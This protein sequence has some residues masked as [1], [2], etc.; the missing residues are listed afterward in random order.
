M[1]MVFTISPLE[2]LTDI[3][4]DTLSNGHNDPI[5][6]LDDLPN[7]PFD[8]LEIIFDPLE[9][10]ADLWVLNCSDPTIEVKTDM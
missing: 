8:L 2:T 3:P 7:V 4:E 6:A 9:A 1:A 10:H 5:E